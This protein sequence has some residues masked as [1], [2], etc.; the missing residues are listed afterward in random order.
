MKTAWQ[1]AMV[2]MVLAALLACA[3]HARV[4]A[5]E[6]TDM[7][8]RHVQ[9]PDR[10]ERVWGSA[11]P[12][13]VLMAMVAPERMVGV[14]LAFEPASR[15]YLPPGLTGLPVLG[16][17]YGIGRVANPE[18]VLAARPQVV[19]AW[20]SFMVDSAMVEAFFA[21]IGVPVVF[22]T[23]DKLADW[24]AA[25]RFTS[26]LL[27]ADAART[28]AQAQYVSQALAK[29]QAAVAPLAE[30]DRLRVYYAEGPAGLATDCHKSF[31][32][33]AIELAGG[34]NVQRCEPSSHVG[35]EAVS[36]EQ[37]IAADPQLIIAQ[38]PQF[39]AAVLKDPRWQG[40]RAVRDG[41]V[42]AVPRWP[43]NWIDRP[44]SA[45]R[46]LGIQWLAHLFYPQR[47]PLDLK[48]ETRQFYRLFLHVEPD[49]AALAALLPP[50]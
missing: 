9:V 43:M 20:K 47:L 8:G 17:V 6:V 16:G 25:L 24:P 18:E 31:H 28:A 50:A 27:G 38:D 10:I 48:A 40:I 46:A 22:V 30:K 5:R 29:V 4:L 39:A 21:K 2:R 13:S 14:N 42:V 26:Q 7:A 23:L 15:A 32:T 36:L 11:P 34:W 44:P 1:H 19:L 33:E 12:L 37:V 3:A 35:M 49:D 45:M 41:R